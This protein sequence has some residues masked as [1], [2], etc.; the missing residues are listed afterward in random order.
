MA[1]FQTI[2]LQDHGAVRVL[3][4]NQPQL[5]NPLDAVSGTELVA[6]LEGADRDP[7]VR[8]LVLTGAGKAFAAGGNVRLMAEKVLGGRPTK[9]FFTEIT[10][11]LNRSIITLRRLSKPVV[12][13]LNGVA[14][15]GGLGW[16]L[17]CD[18]VVA[19]QSARLDPA[20]VRIAVNPD[21]GASALVTRLIGLKRASEFFLLGRVL[22]AQEALEWGMVNRVVEDGQ[23]LPQALELAQALAAGPAKALAAT[24][25]LLN[26]AV[27]GDLEGIL[28]DERQGIIELA[29]QPDFVE[30]IKAFVEKR[31]PQFKD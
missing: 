27:L 31:K 30:G 18:L 13:A 24:K 20:Y 26:R 12:C 28:E 3:T 16:C 5:F 10:A 7:A 19:A 11:I 22:T 29:D 6:A 21:G 8:A 25:A 1:D 17:A 9:P 4:L 14:A 23:L 2:L 15:G